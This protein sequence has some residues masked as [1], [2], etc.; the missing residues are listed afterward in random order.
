MENITVGPRLT[1]GEF[2][3]ELDTRIEALAQAKVLF[4][5]GKV[6]DAYAAFANYIRESVDTEKY[7][8]LDGRVMKPEFTEELRA[9]AEKIMRHEVKVLGTPHKFDGPIDWE[10]NPT[11]NGYK[12]WTWHLSYTDI[13]IPLARAYRATGDER[14]AK[15][16]IEILLSWIRQ[17]VRCEYSTSAYD[18]KTWR[19]IEAGKRM[20]YWSELIH[21]VIRSPHFTD[22]VIVTV[23]KSIFEHGM[24][25][26]NRYTHG[27]WLFY[28][29]TGV[30]Y[31]C[32]LY[33]VFE[34]C[35][36]WRD[37]VEKKLEEAMNIQIHPDGSQYELAPGYHVGILANI[38]ALERLSSKYGY[39]FTEVF[40]KK[41]SDSVD[42]FIKM[43]MSC[44]SV[45]AIND[46][47]IFQTAT[48]IKGFIKSYHDTPEARF[49]ISGGE[50]GAA[51]SYNSAVLPYAG[52]AVFRTGWG[53]GNSSAFFDAGKFGRDHH[54]EDKLNFLVF[55]S[56]RP[57][58]YEAG[59][60]AYDSSDMRKYAVSTEGHNTVK[61][62]GLGQNRRVRHIW[63]DPTEHTRE[64]IRFLESDRLD[65][66][67]GAYD[68][69]YGAEAP[70]RLAVHKR[71]VLLLK[72]P[73][74]GAPIYIAADVMES[75]EEHTYE[76]LWHVNCENVRVE[77]DRAI[78]SDVTIFTS[79][80]E[81]ISCYKGQTEPF[82]RGYLC[83]GT[84]LGNYYEAPELVLERRGGNVSFAT[85]FSLGSPEECAVAGFSIEDCVL[86]I[87]YIDGSTDLIRLD[88]CFEKAKNYL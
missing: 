1:D 59:T 75:S 58:I 44:G 66:A 5:L 67:F 50:E 49:I 43:T 84:D 31:I 74:L 73:K 10:A 60:Y 11:P 8:S 56:D 7:F 2:F 24:R 29:L 69:E 38:S 46:S 61:V 51:P 72:K 80:F 65:Y 77:G 78:S 87:D 39:K 45:P 47:A 42:Y 34:K 36:L 52:F 40:Y 41:M 48:K 13:L 19:T 76:A 70:A 23:F 21:S 37:G 6:E 64:D 14:Y 27:N 16:G 85:L 63:A 4:D 32:T 83:T 3:A 25:L 28:E 57:V 54:H 18:T 53:K 12:E 9:S 68:M 26:V 22:S 62:D 81:K 79:G 33:P 88:D 86:R 15:E 82:I 20:N 17:A 35:D 30:T 71:H 55:N